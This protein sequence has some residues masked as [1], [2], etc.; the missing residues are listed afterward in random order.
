MSQ[1]IIMAQA[2]LIAAKDALE[3]VIELQLTE[4]EKSLVSK[5]AASVKKSIGELKL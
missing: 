2:D 1:N 4:E 3:K 5:S